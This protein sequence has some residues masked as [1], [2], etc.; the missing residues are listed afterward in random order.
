MYHP[1]EHQPLFQ[2]RQY[3]HMVIGPAPLS[4]CKGCL[5]LEHH[6][7]IPVYCVNK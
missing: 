3:R 4:C 6:Q 2:R 1:V 7:L 5:F